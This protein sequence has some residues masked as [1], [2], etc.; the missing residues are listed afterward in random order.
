MEL[1]PLGRDAAKV[2]TGYQ[3]GV[4]KQLQLQERQLCLETLST[5]LPYKKIALNPLKVVRF[6]TLND[7][8]DNLEAIW[9]PIIRTYSAMDCVIPLPKK[10]LIVGIQITVA[11]SH[12]IAGKFLSALLKK[13]WDQFMFAFVH[14]VNYSRFKPQPVK[15]GK[16]QKAIPVRQFKFDPLADYL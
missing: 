11:P 5:L 14:G 10:K 7:I 4:M 15:R 6:E 8:N 16:K 2:S 1:E 12:P 9:F 3:D 13:F